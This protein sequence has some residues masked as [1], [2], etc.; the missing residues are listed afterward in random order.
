MVTSDVGA[1]PL[2]GVR[3]LD[4]TTVVMG[5]YATQILGD[6]GADVIVVEGT[7]LEA[8]R[9]MGPG[10]HPQLSGTALNLMRN[11]RSLRLDFKHPAGRDALL[12][13]AASCDVLV[14]NIRPSGLARAGLTYEDVA[15]VRPDIVYCEAHG[16]PTGSNRAD[17]PAY[18]DVIQAA[19]GVADA[20]RLQ[21]GTPRLV[22]T[23]FVD[24]LCGLT[25]AYSVIAALFRRERTG[26][27]ERVEVPMSET[28]ASFV[29]VEHGAGAIP[30]PALAPAGYSRILSPNRRPQ[31]TLDGWIHVLPYSRAHYEALFEK[32]G[33]RSRVDPALYASGRA[34]IENADHL[35]EQVH[36]VLST[37]T[38]A[39]WMA[40]C[41]EEGVPATEVTTLAALV[42]A[43]P[44]VEHPVAGA[45]RAIPAPVRFGG[46]DGGGRGDGGGCGGGGRRD[47]RGGGEATV[48]RTA[49]APRRPAPL[50][51]QH[52]DEV[53]A[54]VGLSP[55]AIARLRA[56]GAIP[57]EPTDR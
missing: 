1:G 23:I 6:L 10:P 40:Y 54:E 56:S 38:T 25:I 2:D 11:K 16:W 21:T 45:Y 35:Y 42:E 5:P 7:T 36:G 26:Q 34:R 33:E 43:L 19:T 32:T 20:F 49:P 24:K 27:G 53:L 22:P 41:R 13:V 4:L 3:V 15:A 57:A 17:D 14:T 28:A 50:V 39:E 52:T 46:G 31:Q 8:N 12:R 30:R 47:A 44:V 48:R 29:L 9:L 55:A 18:D 51:G 37:R